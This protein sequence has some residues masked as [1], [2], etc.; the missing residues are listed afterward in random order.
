MEAKERVKNTNN[1]ALQMEVEQ[2][3]VLISNDKTNN[4]DT[5]ATMDVDTELE[6]NKSEAIRK[7][8][9]YDITKKDLMP[10]TP[11]T[12]TE[13][14]FILPNPPITSEVSPL[15]LSQSQSLH[16]LKISYC[17]HDVGSGLK[18]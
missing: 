17:R 3:T 10:I 8:A 13:T 4:G 5:V 2:E 7:D 15:I 16:P 9:S 1:E 11:S 14:S 12:H 6:E 18:S